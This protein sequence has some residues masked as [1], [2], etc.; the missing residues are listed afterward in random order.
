MLNSSSAFQFKRGDHICVFYRNA[1]TLLETIAPYIV[2]GLRKGERCFCAQ[3]PDFIPRLLRALEA[4]GVDTHREMQRGA[5]EIHS[6]DEVYFPGGKF[7]PQLMMEMLMH[8]IQDALRRG[9]S[10]F[11]TAGEMSWALSG[12]EGCDQLL[13]YEKMVSAGFPDQPAIGICQYPL[14]GF[15]PK[16]LREVIAT[17]RM[18]L[19]QTM[20]SSNH[21]A[22][23]VRCGEYIADIVGDRFDPAGVFHYVVQKYGGNDLLGWGIETTMDAAIQASRSLIEDLSDGPQP[24]E[25]QAP[26]V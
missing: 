10:G 18:A 12:R 24:L 22:L 3:K 21:S 25:A 4:H 5:L 20:I 16:L 11:R 9:Y 13:G 17:H 15:P 7:E 1:G 14:R 19:E 2:D 6:E 26:L 8:S 23:S